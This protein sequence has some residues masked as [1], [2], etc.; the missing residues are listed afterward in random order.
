MSS[1]VKGKTKKEAEEIFEKF[2]DLVTGKLTDD[3]SIEQ[4]GKLATLQA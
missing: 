4:L 1:V 3:N 2:H